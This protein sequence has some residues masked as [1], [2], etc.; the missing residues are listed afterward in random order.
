MLSQHSSPGTPGLAPTR[1]LLQASPSSSSASERLL[2]L[3]W[4]VDEAGGPG[5]RDYGLIFSALLDLNDHESIAAPMPP[6]LRRSLLGHAQRQPSGY[7]GDFK[8]IDHILEKRPLSDEPISCRWDALLFN[9]VHA[10]AALRSRRRLFETLIGETLIGQLQPEG[11]VRHILNLGSGPCRDV[12][13][14]LATTERAQV[15]CVDVDP[16]ALRFAQ[17]VCAAVQKRVSFRQANALQFKPERRYDLIW[18]AGVCD[19]LSDELFVFFIRKYAK[20][21]TPGGRLVVGNFSESCRSIPFVSQ[22]LRWPLIYRSSAQLRALSERAG[23][24]SSR[25][26]VTHG[27]DG[28]IDYL[29]ISN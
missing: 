4:K 5:P 22:I 20:A 10:A 15:V 23:L 28:A 12:A 2:Q 6:G 18:S 19:Y 3:L 27:N 14:S 24:A 29:H 9:G 16:I 13:N 25:V 8:L 1:Q 21:L 11:D 26:S 7:H 17:R